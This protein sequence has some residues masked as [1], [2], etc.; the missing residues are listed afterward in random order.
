VVGAAPGEQAGSAIYRA[1]IDGTLP[2]G[3][4]A[5][6]RSAAGTRFAVRSAA[7]CICPR[8]GGR[9]CQPPPTTRSSPAGTFGQTVLA[10][11]LALVVAANVALRHALGQA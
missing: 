7:P 9:A 5:G 6:T 3:I 11:S 4:P 1:Q 8:T 2:S 10:T